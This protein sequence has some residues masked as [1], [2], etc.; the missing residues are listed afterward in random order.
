MFVA[1]KPADRTNEKLLRCHGNIVATSTLSRHAY[2]EPDGP[3]PA[4]RS[5][6]RARRCVP[7]DVAAGDTS[8]TEREMHQVNLD[9][10]LSLNRRHSRL[11]QRQRDL[12]RQAATNTHHRCR[13]GAATAV[14]RGTM[15]GMNVLDETQFLEPCE[16]T[17]DRRIVELRKT[18]TDLLGSQ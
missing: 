15:T 12:L 1:V 9:A 17:V 3:S 18:R 16:T 7:L 10:R 8:A 13:R 4:E 14:H 2:S 5:T 11:Q 6:D